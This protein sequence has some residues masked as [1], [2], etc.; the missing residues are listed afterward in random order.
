MKKAQKN[1]K[2]GIKIWQIATMSFFLAAFYHVFY[3]PN[4]QY[5]LVKKIE[6][7]FEETGL[8]TLK[9]SD[10]TD[11][12]WDTLC[13]ASMYSWFHF[14]NPGGQ[15][16]LF[17]GKNYDALRWNLLAGWSPTFLTNL[18]FIKDSR[19]VKTYVF[20]TYGLRHDKSRGWYPY[21]QIILKDRSTHFWGEVPFK[22]E[23]CVN[24]ENGALVIDHGHLDSVILVTNIEKD[25]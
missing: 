4:D 9:I 20:D 17:Y 6:K 10:F 16:D 24:R 3:I 5:T 14:F 13:L 25:D 22:N 12:E 11:F 7:S 1:Y 18:I 23:A 2:G 19:V 21:T 8:D 15:G